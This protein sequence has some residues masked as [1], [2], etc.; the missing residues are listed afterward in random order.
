[1]R[2]ASYAHQIQETAVRL[3]EIPLFAMLK[4]RLGYLTARQRELLHGSIRFVDRSRGLAAQVLGAGRSG[5]RQ[6]ARP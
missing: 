3:D 5:R 2:A 1:M 6:R 4:G